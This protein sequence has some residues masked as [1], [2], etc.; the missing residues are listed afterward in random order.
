MSNISRGGEL[1]GAGG[2]TG[3]IM[4]CIKKITFTTLLF[5]TSLFTSSSHFPGLFLPFCLCSCASLLG[6][7]DLGRG[8]VLAPHFLVAVST[9]D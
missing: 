8:Q 6:E 2:L 5:L 4:V 9:P 3:T 1:G 7:E